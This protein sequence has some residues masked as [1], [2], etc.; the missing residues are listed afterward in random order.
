[1]SEKPSREEFQPHLDSLRKIATDWQSAKARNG[2]GWCW[3]G[4]E[5][6]RAYDPHL[7]SL[8]DDIEKGFNSLSEYVLKKLEIDG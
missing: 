5:I 3:P 2:R 8:I 7:A 6:I 1:M 4:H